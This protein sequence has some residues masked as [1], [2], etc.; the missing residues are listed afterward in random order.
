MKTKENQIIL[1]RLLLYAK[2]YVFFLLLAL[3]CALF[4]VGFSLLTPIFIGQAV[5]SILGLDAV[6]FTSLLS[7]LLLLGGTILASAIFQWL[8][9]YFTNKITFYTIKDLRKQAFDKLNQVPLSY[10]DRTAHGNIMNTMV[11][12][13][14]AISDGLLQ[15]FAQLFT[16]IVTVLGTILLMLRLN[17]LIGLLVIILT[18]LSLFVASFIS[19]RTYYKF[20]EQSALKG[21]MSGFIEEMIGNQKIV[22]TFSYEDRAGERFQNLNQQLHECGVMAQFYSS[23]T[24]PCTRFVNGIVYAAVGILGAFVAIEGKISI[25]QLSSFL[26]YANQYTKP[27]NEISGVITELQSALASARRVFL[28]LDEEIE[29][30]D[31]GLIEDVIADGNVNFH[32]V[33]FSYQK[34]KSLIENFNLTVEAGSRVAIVG[35][36]GSGKST[37][38]NLLMRFYDVDQGWIEVGQNNIQDI[39]RKTL[40]SM[41]GM[42]LQ[43]TWLFSGTVSENIAYGKADATEEEI[44]AAAKAVH[45]HGFIKRLPE[46]YNTII[47]EDGGN[48]SVG[49]KQLLSIA[50]VMLVEP[51]MLILD[52]ATSN[53]DTL[54]EIKIQQ[55]FAKLMKGRTSFVVAHR[56]STIQESDLI[57]VMN[58]GKII[59]QGTHEEL[60]EQ[61]GFYSNLYES[62][63]VAT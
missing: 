17:L 26:S 38:I 61:K 19:K 20:K 21:E 39:K 40:R 51:A 52:E 1:K 23:L 7:I 2:P 36:T 46:G 8:M 5:D 34:E 44:V 11:N 33:S 41:F 59:E 43:D 6:D 4:G 56:L 18:P 15:G 29:I 62:Q 3:C 32:Q 9:T 48:L 14:D 30:V 12:D 53:I 13:I 22:K 50:R 25:G 55:A 16:G 58:Q 37:L 10:I 57:L 49:Q 27:F 28:L 42:V 60:L 47:S 54:T 63:F 35:P 31:E 24:N 45:A